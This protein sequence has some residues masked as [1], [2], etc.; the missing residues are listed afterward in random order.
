[1]L[2]ID[3]ASASTLPSR[4]W[5]RETAFETGSPRVRGWRRREREDRDG[6]LPGVCVRPRSVSSGFGGRREQGA[7]EIDA[8]P[9]L[10]A[11]LAARSRRANLRAVEVASL[12]TIGRFTPV[13][14]SIAPS[15]RN[16]DAMFVGVPPNMSVSNNTPAPCDTRVIARCTSS[17]AASTSSCQPIDTAAMCEIGPTIISA[18]ASSS[19]ARCPCV[20]ITPATL[21][22]SGL[23]VS[24]HCSVLT[25]I[26]KRVPI[27]F[28]HVTM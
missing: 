21:F 4:R 15:S 20:T 17:R 25:P 7:G 22:A 26:A 10:V 16:I 28:A 6:W 12:M 11:N 19:P 3:F 24:T 1:M 23:K 8:L 14:T 18:A 2:R 5:R 9:S 13:T 27:C